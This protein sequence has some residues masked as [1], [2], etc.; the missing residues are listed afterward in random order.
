MKLKP[1]LGLGAAVVLTPLAWAGG[2]AGARNAAAAGQLHA[3]SADRAE[4]GQRTKAPGI[5]SGTNV[6]AR[7]LTTLSSRKAKPGQRVV[8]RVMKDVKRHGRVVI[9]RD[10]RIV[11]RVVTARASGKGS[12]GS[13]LAVTFDRLVQGKNSRAVKAVVTA[14]VHPPMP[15]TAPSMGMQQ[16]GGAPAMNRGGGLAG[17]AVSTARSPAAVTHR[18]A[19]GAFGAAG[20]MTAPLGNMMPRNPIV[21]TSHAAVARLNSSAR[22]SNRT[23]MTSVFSR[24]EGNLQVRS[25]TQL[26]FRV[27]G[28]APTRKPAPHR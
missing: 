5:R 3:Q 16:P 22:V 20:G 4:T 21:V 12:A 26:Q 9:R 15:L 8:A 7:L 25:G 24:R 17:G 19:G 2:P 13:S 10:S 11:G 18:T 6:S 23:A 14:I 28:N 27:V 1:I